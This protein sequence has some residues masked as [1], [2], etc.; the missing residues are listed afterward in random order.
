M[1]KRAKNQMDIFK[2]KN[3]QVNKGK[4]Y[5]GMI[6]GIGC[7][8]NLLE[9]KLGAVLKPYNLSVVKF[10]ILLVTKHVG[11][12]TGITQ[13]TISG[14]L[15]VSTSNMSRLI[16]SLEREG[17]IT[18]KTNPENRREKLVHISE[19]GSALLEEIWPKYEARAKDLGNLLDQ[20]DQKALSNLV[21]KWADR[22]GE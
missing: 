14:K 13:E 6:Y 11:G 2:Q 21:V 10:N 18:R 7:A 19:K 9:R 20:D 3:I 12:P 4:P 22:L 17:L 5:E 1:S 15:V 8:Y 16:D